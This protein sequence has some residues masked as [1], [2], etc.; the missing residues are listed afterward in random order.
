MHKIISTRP[1]TTAYGPWNYFPDCHICK[2]MK[3]GRGNT[4]EDLIQVFAETE[5]LNR[6]LKQDN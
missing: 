6:K 5:A 2:A 4:V 1:K 3:Q